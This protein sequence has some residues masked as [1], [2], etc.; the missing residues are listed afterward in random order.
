MPWKI[1]NLDYD[2]E[3]PHM[4]LADVRSPGMHM[5]VFL[6]DRSVEV[7]VG[8]GKNI[9]RSPVQ[10]IVTP[11]GVEVH[12]FWFKGLYAKILDHILVSLDV[13]VEDRQQATSWM[14][15]R[16]DK[17]PG[18]DPFPPDHFASTSKQP[19]WIGNV[20]GPAKSFVQNFGWPFDLNDESLVESLRDPALPEPRRNAL[21]AE[22]RRRG[23]VGHTVDAERGD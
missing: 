16:M 20:T 7:L 5:R 18:G 11:T 12:A 3:R 19:C 4:H 21:F 14:R 15:E 8:G 2:A 10:A 17:T 1:V 6:D 22:A 9:Y 13:S 23:F